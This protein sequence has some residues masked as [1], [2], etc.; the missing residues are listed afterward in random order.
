MPRWMATSRTT[1]SQLILTESTKVLMPIPTKVY[2]TLTS[3]ILTACSNL[4]T[5]PSVMTLPGTGKSF[6]QFL[7][8]D[9]ICQQFAY[10]HIG[11]AGTSSGINTAP[12]RSN[13]TSNSSYGEQQYRYDM[14]Y[15]QCMYAKGHRVPVS[16]QI[17]S[18]KSVGRQQNVAPSGRSTS[19]FT[20]PPPPKGPPPPP[21]PSY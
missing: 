10:T 21:P 2:I 16:G 5:T 19:G 17:T 7:A 15:I 13:Y 20:P 14:S 8:D 9:Q 3:L 11:G 1:S 18:D 4:P 6:D 12:T